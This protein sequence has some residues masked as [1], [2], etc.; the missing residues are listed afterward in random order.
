MLR[1]F[2][3]Q[4]KLY[5]TVQKIRRRER[6]LVYENKV[7]SFGKRINNSSFSWL[8]IVQYTGFLG[9]KH[10]LHLPKLLNSDCRSDRTNAIRN[11][12]HF[13]VDRNPF[14]NNDVRIVTVIFARLLKKVNAIIYENNAR[15]TQFFL[16]YKENFPISIIRIRIRINQKSE[17]E[18]LACKVLR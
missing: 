1:K 2:K 17:T 7:Q 15:S 16:R 8:F 12:R 10:H 9:H 14:G 18:N 6:P 5:G 3:N 11:Y 4:R 13:L